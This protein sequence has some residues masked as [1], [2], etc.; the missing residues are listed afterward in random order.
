[1]IFISTLSFLYKSQPFKAIIRALWSLAAIFDDKQRRSAHVHDFQPMIYLLYLPQWGHSFG[2]VA[3]SA[4]SLNKLHTM[5]FTS[6]LLFLYKS[7]QLLGPNSRTRYN[8]CVS[9][10]TFSFFGLWALSTTLGPFNHRSVLEVWKGTRGWYSFQ[11]NILG[12]ASHI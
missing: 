5:I 7:Q 2:L 10:E 9:A 6:R 8:D 11:Y 12:M 3:S 4:G 1:M